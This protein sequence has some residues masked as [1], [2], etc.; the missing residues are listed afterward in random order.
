V[1]VAL[2]IDH[3]V[4]EQITHG[5]RQRAVDVLTAEDDDS[6][7]LRDSPLLARATGLGRPIFSMDHDFLCI[8]N[9]WNLRGEMFAGVIFARQRRIT[10][11]KAI[12]D[13]EMIATVLDPEDLRNQVIF[14]PL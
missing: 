6:A 3:N 8:A 7:T 1:T 10:F 13:L 5:L 2:Y 9:E 4:P 12:D 14:L 11:R